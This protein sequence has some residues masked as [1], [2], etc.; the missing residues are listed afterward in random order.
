MP[1]PKERRL[2]CYD[3]Y[4]YFLIYCRPTSFETKRKN[5]R[6]RII[7][8]VWD[9]V[10]IKYF[11]KGQEKWPL[12][13]QASSIEYERGWDS[14]QTT[15]RTKMNVSV[16][17]LTQIKSGLSFWNLF[18]KFTTIAPSQLNTQRHS[19]NAY[20][21]IWVVKPSAFVSSFS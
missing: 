15:F 10:N 20:M 13:C 7:L 18:S 21:L 1:M 11:E 5:L 3:Q 4:R 14:R 16:T 19:S 8:P 12:Q 9:L 2:I 17:I 6:L